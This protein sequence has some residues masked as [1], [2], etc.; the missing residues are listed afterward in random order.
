MRCEIC[1]SLPLCHSS[2]PFLLHKPA[3]L[4]Y[5]KIYRACDSYKAILLRLYDHI[6]HLFHFDL[7]ILIE[8]ENPRNVKVPEDVFFSVSEFRSDAAALVPLN[9]TP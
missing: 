2:F 4:Q 5:L 3:L 7:E 9:K 6:K 1:T 8:A